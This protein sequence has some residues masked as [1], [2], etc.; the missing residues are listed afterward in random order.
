MFKEGNSKL[1]HYSSIRVIVQIIGEETL[2][3][4]ANGAS[5]SFID[6]GFVARKNLPTKDM[7]G[8]YVI[9][10]NYYYKV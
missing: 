10:A 1:P 6:K 8:I 9:N 4:I 3:M 5:R 2:I 7:E